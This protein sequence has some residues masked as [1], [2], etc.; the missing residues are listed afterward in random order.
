MSTSRPH[1]LA[2]GTWRG[3]LRSGVEPSYGLRR[4]T[5]LCG[6]VDQLFGQSSAHTRGGA[7]A[8]KQEEL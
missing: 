1:G 3:K 6:H 8:R 2:D 7:G 5:L 4:S